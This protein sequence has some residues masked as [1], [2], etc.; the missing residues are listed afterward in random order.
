MA[1]GSEVGGNHTIDIVSYGVQ[2]KTVNSQ[3][4]HTIDAPHNEDTLLKYLSLFTS[5]A[6]SA[7]SPAEWLE[8]EPVGR[9]RNMSVV[10][11][12]LCDLKDI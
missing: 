11:I 1:L 12:A 6:F 7:G 3:H 4:F 9:D 10:S 2:L 8:A 5:F